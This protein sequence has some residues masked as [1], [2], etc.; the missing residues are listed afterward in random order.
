MK[1]AELKQHILTKH[2]THQLHAL[3]IKKLPDHLNSLNAINSELN[4]KFGHNNQ[5]SR[6]DRFKAWINRVKEA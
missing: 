5:P 3:G 4:E 6:L 1:K 2:G